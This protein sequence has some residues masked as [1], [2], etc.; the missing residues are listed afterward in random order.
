MGR[1]KIIDGFSL[2]QTSTGEQLQ[3]HTGILKS[4]QINQQT[5]DHVLDINIVVITMDLND[6]LGVCWSIGVF[7]NGRDDLVVTKIENLFFGLIKRSL[8]SISNLTRYDSFL[9]SMSSGLCK[10]LR[11]VLMF[12][13]F[14]I[15]F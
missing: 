12:F 14:L 7:A 2:T 3:L 8:N 11:S 9:R 6:V 5:L 13:E 1:N 10:V 15:G 4:L